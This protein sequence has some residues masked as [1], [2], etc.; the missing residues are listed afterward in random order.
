MNATNSPSDHDMPRRHFLKT[1]AA[2]LAAGSLAG[3]LSLSRSAHAAGSETIRIGFIGCG[4]RGTGACKDVLS[5]KAPVKLV[6]VGDLFS[7]R[8]QLSLKNLRK[9]PEINAKIDAPPERCFTGF[10]AYQK[11]IDSDVDL[12]LLATPPHFR[13]IHYA[14]AVQAGK[15]VFMEKPLCVDAPGY[16][17]LVAAN[18]V[19]LRKKLSVVVGLQRRHQQNY[20]EGIKKLHQGEIG[21]IHLARVYF[22][23]PFGGRSGHV[24]PAGM[25]EMEYQ[26]RQWGVF[27]WLCGDHLVEQ[28]TH[29]I[30]VANWAMNAHPVRANGMGGR[31]VRRGPGNGDIWD[32]HF[33]EFEYADGARLYCQARQQP[34]T[35]SHVSDNFHGTKGVMTIGTGPWGFGQAGPRELR[36]K[37][38][39]QINPYSQEHQDLIA[40]IR[41]EGPYRMEG[42]YGAT[43]TMTSVMGRMATYSGLQVTWDEAV[44]STQRL[45]PAHYAFDADPPVLPDPDGGYPTAMP[46]VNKLT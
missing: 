5:L 11:V 22:N 16:R 17:D 13:P 26:I 12:V 24:K 4:N 18:E 10:D 40:S 33:I 6:A 2:A 14:A 8:L 23:V 31:Q 46:G 39:Q 41:G 27:C 7:D 42:D 20:L 36:S 45:A 19:A 9:Y 38:M 1:S 28:A 43:S 30:D 35:W 21:T 25:S 44:S 29:E 3:G 15:H 34:G 37:K 32:H